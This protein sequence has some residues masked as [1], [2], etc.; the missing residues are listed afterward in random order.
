MNAIIPN[1][2]Y[3]SLCPNCGGE[4]TFYA[5]SVDEHMFTFRLINHESCPNL[6]N[7]GNNLTMY[8]YVGSN[9]RLLSKTIRLK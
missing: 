8:G 3:K 9:S 7:F 1:N 5:E 4:F 2:Y 6:V